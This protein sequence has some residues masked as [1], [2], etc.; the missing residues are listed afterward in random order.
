MKAKK[1]IYSILLVLFSLILI[2]DLGVWFFIPDTK[3]SVSEADTA[4]PEFSVPDGMTLS[5]DVSI[6]ESTDADEN[7]S[8]G[9][10]TMP[11]GMTLP[12]GADAS[13]GSS[14][15]GMTIPEGMTSPNGADNGE[16]SSVGG[17]VAP[18]G[19]SAGGNGM[20]EGMTAPEGTDFSGG[21]SGTEE[22]AGN[23]P[24]LPSETAEAGT[25][26]DTAAVS[27]EAEETSILGRAL[28]IG[29]LV[30]PYQLYILIGSALGFVLCIIRLIFINRK[31]RKIREAEEAAGEV[32]SVRRVALWPALLL[33]LASLIL[34]V[35]LYPADD[36]E[37]AAEGAV[38]NTELLTGMAEVKSVTSLI[39]A[40]G[41]LEEQESVTLTI[42]S[43]I[44]VE[45]VCVQNGD[46]VNAG[47]V[48]AKADL[49]SVMQA[50]ANVHKDLEDIDEQLQKAHEAKAE[51]PITA[52]VAGTVKEVYVQPGDNA[53]DVMEQYGALMLLSLDARMAVNVPASDALLIGTAVTVTLSD[54][55]EIDGEV[56]FLEE[57][58]AIVTVLDRGYAIGEQVSVKTKDG[59]L[60]GS[61]ALYVHKPLHVTGYIGTVTKVYREPGNT[62]YAG[63]A[64]IGLSDTSDL[65]EYRQLL[66]E[67][68]EYEEE[69]K[70]LFEIYQTGY[71]FAPEDGVVSDLSE[72]LPY[73]PFIPPGTETSLNVRRLSAGPQDADPNEYVH[74]AGQVLE[75]AGG[76]LSLRIAGPVAVSD[77]TSIPGVSGSAMTGTYTIPGSAPVWLY[78]GGWS[79]IS[80]GD[81]MAGDK[82]LFT[83]DQN[84]SL[85]WVIVQHTSDSVTPTPE[86]GTTPNPSGEPETSPIPDGTP[87]P[88]GMPGPSDMPGPDTSPDTSSDPNVTPVPSPSSM[89]DGGGGGG[90]RPGGG[91][92]ISFGGFGG[93][94]SSTQK[95]PAYTIGEQNLLS[96]TPQEKMLITVSV[97]EHDL[98]KIALGQD[99]DLYLDAHP[100]EKFTATVTKI[101]PEGTNNGGNTKY[102][103]TLAMDR[104]DQ[105]LPGMNGTVCFPKE[106]KEN[107]LTVP[108]AAIEE[109]GNSV[110]V[111]TGYDEQTDQLILPVEVETGISDGTDVEIL[112]GLLEGTV[113]WYR[114]AESISYATTTA[115]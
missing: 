64:L 86:P 71:L 83:F 17:N 113:Y 97:D 41:S 48:V 108:L 103:V 45:S 63:Q 55:T 93:S 102:S 2:A 80:S 29:K 69:L 84:G 91:G 15:G 1:V 111:Y 32:V 74:Y 37:K 9:G 35:L 11:E 8:A 77:Y 65:A 99:V 36:T 27:E 76:L 57:G 87:A 51:T 12:E 100:N 104:T 30:K 43:S 42:P 107:V 110:V 67:R 106:T 79:A 18:E 4:A 53:I 50:I 54:G 16:N 39:Q 61:G 60:A 52:A 85:V 14:A 23:R 49:I 31:L 112:S 62:V 89:P 78:S 59:T 115:E 75:N 13:E 5:E 73:E 70:T 47:Q 72:D 94:G 46:Q 96:V 25:A 19:S 56:N 3:S 20:P 6:P 40:A 58:T 34:V 105:L 26:D 90:F 33:L 38:A 22:D 7:S 109:K 24:E 101:D 92:G 98:L 28:A 66:K 68:A 21:S 114:F 82:I 81:I 10:M 88:S 95:E 44:S